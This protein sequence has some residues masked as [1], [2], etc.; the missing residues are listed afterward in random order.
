M[1]KCE[2]LSP[3][4]DMETLIAAVNN[5][6]D[7]VYV[8]GKMF[9]ARAFA[10]NF[11][12]D[13]LEKA[14]KY[15]HLYGV[16][17]YVTANTIIF[18]NE[19][20]EFLKYMK[21]LYEIN[22]DA[23][24]M[25][26]LGMISL[27]RK[28]IPNLEIHA[29]TQMNCYNDESLNLL[30]NMGVKRAVLAREMSLDEILA[31]KCPIEKEIFIHGALCV[32]Y[33]G[34]CLFSYLNGGRSGNRGSCSGSCRLNYELLDG[35]VSKGYFL[36]TK[37]LCTVDYIK[38]I[39]DANIHSLKIEGRMKSPSYVGYVTKVYRRLIDEYYLGKNPKITKEEMINLYKLFNREFTSGYLFKNNIYNSK[40]PNH[41]GYPLGKVIKQDKGKIY[42]KL[43]DD[44]H[45]EDGIRFC[46]SNKGMIVNKLYNEQGLLVNHLCKGEIAVIDN[47]VNLINLDM[48]NK[49]IDYFLVNEKG[50]IKKIPICFKVLAKAH[51]PLKLTI[52]DGVNEIS[53]KSVL[54][55]EARNKVTSEDEVYS[56]L[57]KLGSTPF[58]LDKCEII[59]NNA[60][61]P[62]K[63]LNEL[64]RKAC[65]ELILKRY[66]VRNKISF[67][68]DKSLNND[69]NLKY[70]VLVRNENQLKEFLGMRIY[71]E[72]YDLYKKYKDYDVYYKLPRIMNEYPNFEGEKLLVSDLGSVYK[73]ALNN[74]VITDYPLN[75]SNSESVKVLKNLGVKVVT[76]S[77]EADFEEILKHV[78]GI[79][80]VIYGRPDLMI[81]KNFRKGDYLKRFD[82]YFP[83]IHGKYVTILHH[84][85]IC[86]KKIGRII[87]FDEDI[88]DLRKFYG[89]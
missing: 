56:K 1:D 5:G 16:H 44:L 9:G 6:A 41:L 50:P 23:V 29:S 12:Y 15:C 78:S 18:E 82:D 87:L 8:G 72:D 62:M 81:L 49:T 85:N 21:F 40:S 65:D 67:K 64:R 51:E 83:I 69:F 39:L 66:G 38:E 45:Q 34:Q 77:L 26:D 28:L 20:D 4:G 47:K 60:F 14:V 52:S 88:N 3:A 19:I 55:D 32:S 7:A 33:S 46:E 31:L 10:K 86:L 71:T 53:L 37:D 76:I 35:N 30:F 42:I 84:E 61:I 74:D 43:T 73:Y 27:V 54:L 25:Q 68:Y 2:L 17:L 22:V 79:E 63:F 24:I 13:E 89:I 75:V 11:S 36:S 70:S 58:Y 48:V 57:C 59:I 80:R